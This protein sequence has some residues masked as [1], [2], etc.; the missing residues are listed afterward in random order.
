M[1]AILSLMSPQL[2]VFAC[3]AAVM[4]GIVKGMVGFAMPMVMVSLL[5][6]MLPP[7]VA[8]AGLIVPTVLSNIIQGLRQGP[9]AALRSVKRF[10]RFLLVGM[11]F[12]IASAQLFSVLD[13]HTLYLTIGGP[14]ALFAFADLMG[15]RFKM[16]QKGRHAIEAAF[17]AVAGFIGG[18]S[19]IWG[20]PTVALLTALDTKKEEQMRVQGVIY[21]LGGIALFGAHIASGVMRAQTFPFSLSLVPAALLGLWIGFKI[22]DRFDQQS[23]RK[24]TLLVLLIAGLN[25]VRRGIMG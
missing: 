21:G 13:T 7:D 5:T 12:L 20:P 17:G 22:Q 25:L 8:L 4:A 1:D 23:F 10:W 15:W 9:G 11:V 2:F 16:P 24:M 14:I 6:T 19:G 18:L 3:C